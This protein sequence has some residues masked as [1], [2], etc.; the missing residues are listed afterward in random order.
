MGT[1]ETCFSRSVLSENQNNTLVLTIR[2][3]INDPQVDNSEQENQIVF[4]NL[5]VNISMVSLQSAARGYLTR[6]IFAS[7]LENY[8]K[9]KALPLISSQS[10]KQLSQNFKLQDKK[11]HDLSFSSFDIEVL[12]LENKKSIN[13]STIKLEDSSIIHKIHNKIQK[14]NN[15]NLLLDDD[16]EILVLFNESKNKDP[17]LENGTYA[18]E[19][20]ENKEKCIKSENEDEDINKKDNQKVEE[21]YQ[22]YWPDGTKYIDESGYY[23]QIHVRMISNSYKMETKNN[24]SLNKDTKS[25]KN[26]YQGEWRNNKKHGK[27]VYKW[28][29]GR[30]Y[31]GNWKKDLYDGYGKMIWPDGS[32]YKGEWRKGKQHGNGRYTYMTN[33]K[34]ITQ[35]GIWV[36]GVIQDAD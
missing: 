35:T 24:S 25:K 6:K 33:N 3:K 2:P 1:C 10:L 16:N 12:E 11:Q 9:S 29:D 15:E 17:K 21:I 28:A 18:Q 27:G 30:V 26:F 8:Q 5:N 20:D 31:S 22:K 23:K 19:T 13:D 34:L 4:I 32:K 14:G 7:Q 36:D